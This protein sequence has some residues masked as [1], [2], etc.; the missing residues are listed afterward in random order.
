MD[1]GSEFVFLVE[2]QNYDEK[3][4]PLEVVQPLQHDYG[5]PLRIC[6]ECRTSIAE[7]RQIPRE[8]ASARK[9]IAVLYLRVLAVLFIA[10]FLCILYEFLAYQLR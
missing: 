9:R 8:Q 2:A 10:T 6:R 7:N 5:E 3:L 4:A 1:P